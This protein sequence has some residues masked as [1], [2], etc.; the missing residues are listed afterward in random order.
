MTQLIQRLN[1]VYTT[2]TGLNHLEHDS[3]L[4]IELS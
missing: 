2:T 3:Q 1:G 4:K